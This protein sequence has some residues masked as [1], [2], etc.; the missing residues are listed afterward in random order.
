MFIA[1]K[2]VRCICAPGDPAGHLTDGLHRDSGDEARSL[3]GHSEK[4][5]ACFEE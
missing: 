3:A 5:A 1:A 4:A 2:R